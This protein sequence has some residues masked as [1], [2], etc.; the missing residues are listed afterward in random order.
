MI[1]LNDEEET[2]VV[3]EFDTA[4]SNKPFVN[5]KATAFLAQD[6]I[7]DEIIKKDVEEY[8]K[9]EINFTLEDK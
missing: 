4:R 2:Q 3:S 8:K 5:K 9:K 1:P 6:G 7:K